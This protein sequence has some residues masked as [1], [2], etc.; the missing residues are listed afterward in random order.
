MRL[1]PIELGDYDQVLALNLAAEGHVSPL[2]REALA[3]FAEHAH[4]V[5]VVDDGGV[6]AAFAVTL[7]P[8][9]TYQSPNYGWFAER[10][11]D[12]LYLDRIAVGEGWRRRGLGSLI[13]DEMERD[14]IAHSRLCCEVDLDPPNPPSLA[15]HASRG[16]HE[17]GQLRNAKGKLL[18]MLTKELGADTA[19]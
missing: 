2:D 9:S 16:Y 3:W 5:V 13:Y 1:R 8:G 10:Y 19:A 12:F 18:T 17:V 15:F 11:G 14:A 7:L 6:A 4:K